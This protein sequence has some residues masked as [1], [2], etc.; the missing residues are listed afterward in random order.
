MLA[1]ATAAAR[2]FVWTPG[3]ASVVDMP[4]P[5][6]EELA[7][8]AEAEEADRQRKMARAA[9]RERERRGRL[10]R[11]GGGYKGGSSK[12]RATAA[13]RAS[14]KLSSHGSAAFPC[15]QVRWNPAGDSLLCSGRSRFLV[16]YLDFS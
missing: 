6:D 11:G 7:A 1:V 15:T 3:G 16:A 14:S 5:S 8:A 12:G 10:G 2:V 13:A 9:E 4:R